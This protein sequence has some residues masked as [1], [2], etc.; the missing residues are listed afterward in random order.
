MRT[1]QQLLTE[2]NL[3]ELIE[4]EDECYF[5]WGQMLKQELL[6]TLSGAEIDQATLDAQQEYS[7]LHDP[8]DDE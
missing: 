4:A 7:D 3:M 8:F 6:E 2:L 1:K 5:E